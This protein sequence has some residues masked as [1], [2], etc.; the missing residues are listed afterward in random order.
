MNTVIT[1]NLTYITPKGLEKLEA[2]LLHL[3]TEKRREIAQYLQETMG[4]SEDNEYLMALDEQAFVEG[5]IRQLEIL[6]S[7]VKVIQP[8]QNQGGVADLG[9]TVVIRDEEMSVETYTI[10]GSAEADPQNGLISNVSPLGK[11]LLGNKVGEDVE[12]KTPSGLLNY[13]ILAIQ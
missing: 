13:R 11:A 7:N 1:E 12:I 10:V 5:R 4:D 6:L 8:G 2:E 3:R 9:S